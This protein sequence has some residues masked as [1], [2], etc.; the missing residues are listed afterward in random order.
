MVILKKILYL[1]NN[2]ILWCFFGFIFLLFLSNLPAEWFFGEFGFI[3][4]TQTIILIYCL[5]LNFQYRKLFVRVSNVF[6]FLLRQLL[7]LVLIY[8]ELSFFTLNSNHLFNSQQEFNLH[9][10]NLMD[11]SLIVF[12]IPI[13]N[14]T[15]TVTIKHLMYSSFLFV[16]GYGSYFPFLKN[17]RYFFLDRQFAIYTNIYIVNLIFFSIT[18]DLNI[19]VD[20]KNINNEFIE[21][22]IYSLLLIDTLKK[23]KIRN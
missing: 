19:L 11:S 2:R 22:L 6:T 1:L 23:R 13:I 8:E 12:I 7:F 5:V 17:L 4:I 20:N 14:L 9:N 10:A 15:Y 3:E 18:Q 21:L 16:L